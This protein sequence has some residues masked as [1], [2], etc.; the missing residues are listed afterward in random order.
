MLPR[1][2]LISG[3]LPDFKLLVSN[4]QLEVDMLN[5]HQQKI[6]EEPSAE[7][8]FGDGRCHAAGGDR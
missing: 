6:W 1:S 5:C 8:V 4:F 2:V 7:K 3:E